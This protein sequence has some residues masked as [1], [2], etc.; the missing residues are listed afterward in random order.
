MERHEAQKILNGRQDYIHHKAKL[1]A[2]QGIEIRLRYNAGGVTMKELAEE[3]GVCPRTISRI[4]TGQRAETA[5]RR[6]LLGVEV[7]L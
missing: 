3:Y 5:Y 1:S 6:I 2:N 4:V 7:R